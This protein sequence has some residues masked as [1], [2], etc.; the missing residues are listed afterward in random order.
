[1]SE[2]FVLTLRNEGSPASYAP[3]VGFVSAAS[4]H[5]ARRFD[6]I[7]KADAARRNMGDAWISRATIDLV[8]LN[9]SAGE[10]P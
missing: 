3:A 7:T 4:L 9:E 10:S 2:F 1:M 6:T 8:E 5:R